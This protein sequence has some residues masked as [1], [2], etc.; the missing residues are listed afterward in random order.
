MYEKI[1]RGTVDGGGLLGK[2]TLLTKQKY[3]KYNPTATNF[4]QLFPTLPPSPEPPSPT[5]PPVIGAFSNAFSNA[6]NT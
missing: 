6:F 1:F 5:P 4:F 2:K 3:K